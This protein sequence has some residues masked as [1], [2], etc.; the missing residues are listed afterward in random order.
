MSNFYLFTKE[1]N[2]LK[3]EDKVHS[4]YYEPYSTSKNLGKKHIF[5]KDI[6]KDFSEDVNA[7]GFSPFLHCK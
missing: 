7:F 2:K 1:F 6:V 4:Y 5:Y 3:V